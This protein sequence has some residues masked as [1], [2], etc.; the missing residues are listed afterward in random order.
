MEVQRNKNPIVKKSNTLINAKLKQKYSLNEIRTIRWAVANVPDS[1]KDEELVLDA[2]E[3]AKLVNVPPENIYREAKNLATKLMSKTLLIEQNDEWIACNWFS[4]IRYKSGKFYFQI[5]EHLVPHIVR[6]KSHFTY[7]HLKT[8]LSL[9]SQYAIRLYELLVQYAKLK[10]RTIEY[11]TLRE[12]LGVQPS[13]LKQFGHFNERV[14]KISEREINLKSDIFFSYELVK[15]SRKVIAITFYIK[16]NLKE[17]NTLN[18]D[19]TKQLTKKL[20]SFGISKKA[21]V[22]L[23][24]DYSVESIREKIELINFKI[25]NGTEIRLPAAYLVNAIVEDY[26]TAE[27][28]LNEGQGN[29]NELTNNLKMLTVEVNEYQAAVNSHLSKF[30]LSIKQQYEKKLLEAKKKLEA[31]TSQLEGQKDSTVAGA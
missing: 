14:L 13:E 20:E 16:P 23:L 19:E 22:T 18:D 6:L 3:L 15:S 4:G 9:N 31:L 25:K 10:K 2:M 11:P 26:S 27:M 29:D 12:L 24:N 8:A 30:D 21:I 1:Y 5:Y 7:Y 17:N 28:K